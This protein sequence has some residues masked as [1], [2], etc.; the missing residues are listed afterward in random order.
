MANYKIFLTDR[1]KADLEKLDGSVQSSI[2]EK[3]N[4]FALPQLVV[5]PQFGINIKKLK[6]FKPETWRYRIGSFRLFYL[7]DSEKMVVTFLAI[8]NRKDAY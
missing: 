8:A 6:N 1:F 2:R 5:T 3:F 7:I 4:E